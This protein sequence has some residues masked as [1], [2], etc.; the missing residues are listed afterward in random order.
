MWK[1]KKIKQ[2]VGSLPRGAV[3][4]GPFDERFWQL[5]SATLGKI[6]PTRVFP[7]L[8]SVFAKSTRQR[9]FF[10]K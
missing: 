4:K 1:A 8:P 7:A 6:F 10:K 3:G 9:I 2:N 5:R